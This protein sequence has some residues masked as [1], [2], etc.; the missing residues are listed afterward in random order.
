MFFQIERAIYHQ[1]APKNTL[2]TVYGTPDL[3]EKSIYMISPKFASLAV[4]DLTRVGKQDSRT[5]KWSSKRIHQPLYTGVER[6]FLAPQTSF[7]D[8]KATKSY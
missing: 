6:A 8:Y 4:S 2:P 5:L 1:K 7:N 3:E